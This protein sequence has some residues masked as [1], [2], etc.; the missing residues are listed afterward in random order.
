MKNIE[1]QIAETLNS[2]DDIQKAEAPYFFNTRVQAKLN[3]RLASIETPWLPKWKPIWAITTLTIL[4]SINIFSVTQKNKN[5]KSKPEVDQHFR[6][7]IKNPDFIILGGGTL[8][9]KG[10]NQGYLKNL[11]EL[12]LSD[13]HKII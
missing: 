10:Y 12:Y 4:L 2:I 6:S 1:I 8:I 9:R 3:Q 7:K 5:P 13:F 11:N